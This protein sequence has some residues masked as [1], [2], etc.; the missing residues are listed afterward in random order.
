MDVEIMF[1]IQILEHGGGTM[2]IKLLGTDCLHWNEVR[3]HL[4][5][6]L[7]IPRLDHHQVKLG[8]TFGSFVGCSARMVSE[9]FV[10]DEVKAQVG[11]Y[12]REMKE[13]KSLSALGRSGKQP[14][15][16]KVM[17]KVSSLLISSPA[18]AF[19]V[20]LYRF[21]GSVKGSE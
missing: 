3:G 14:L 5:D 10:W 15:C 16:F 12:Q 20:V 8:Y 21:I 11:R 4:C 19:V 13:G 6:A 7:K 17:N 2:P 9:D 1:D 18:G